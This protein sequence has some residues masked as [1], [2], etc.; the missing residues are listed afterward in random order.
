MV[1]LISDWLYLDLITG[2]TKN[3][4][5]FLSLVERSYLT[6]GVMFVISFPPPDSL[7]GARQR[8][9]GLRS[10]LV[11]ARP[12]APLVFSDRCFRIE[13]TEV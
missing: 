4:A 9:N 3:T 1:V 10:L 6:I 11:A 8:Q 7:V 12:R 2:K 5:C 13:H